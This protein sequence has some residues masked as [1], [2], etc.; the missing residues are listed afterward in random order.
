[1]PTGYIKAPYWAHYFLAYINNIPQCIQPNSKLWNNQ[2]P[3]KCYQPSEMLRLKTLR[4]SFFRTSQKLNLIFCFIIHS[5]EENNDKHSITSNTLCIKVG[6]HI[7]H[8]ACN[9]KISQ[10]SAGR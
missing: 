3:G 1:M 8:Y 2:G 7:M 4:P 10:L 9:L 5:L 6:N